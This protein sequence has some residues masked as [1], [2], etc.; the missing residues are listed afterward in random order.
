MSGISFS[1]DE[2]LIMEYLTIQNRPYSAT[3]IFNNL[4]GKVSKLT[5][6]KILTNLFEKKAI[7]GKAYGKQWVFSSKHVM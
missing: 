4:H 6:T 1:S 2:K 3:D 7:N 5:V